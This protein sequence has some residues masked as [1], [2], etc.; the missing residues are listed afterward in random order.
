MEKQ[1]LSS[2][3]EICLLEFRFDNIVQS[4]STH[5]LMHN[6]FYYLLLYWKDFPLSSIQK[7][8]VKFF[9]FG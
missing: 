2:Y 3:A 8:V 5:S 4:I 1:S 7:S 6:I 9:Q